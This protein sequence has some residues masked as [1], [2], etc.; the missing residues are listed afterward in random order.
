MWEVVFPRLES[1]GRL[2]V[3]LETNR[4]GQDNRIEI[5]SVHMGMTHHAMRDIL[6]LES[7]SPV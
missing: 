5:I 4:S 7:S 6:D 3:H 2:A 1:T